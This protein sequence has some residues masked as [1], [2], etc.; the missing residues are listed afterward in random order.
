MPLR[1]HL[2]SSQLH[3]GN[4]VSTQ[5]YFTEH[6]NPWTRCCSIRE[7]SF[8]ASPNTPLKLF[9]LLSCTMYIFIVQCTYLGPMHF[10]TYGPLYFCTS[11]ILSDLQYTLHQHKLSVAFSLHRIELRPEC[12]TV[13]GRNVS[14]LIEIPQFYSNLCIGQARCKKRVGAIFSPD[15]QLLRERLLGS[16]I[17]YI[18]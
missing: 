16:G 4:L 12:K 2:R 14:L 6:S 13:R 5:L 8:Q 1:L 10:P 15:H 18:P 9:A 17:I 7:Y 11:I 3:V